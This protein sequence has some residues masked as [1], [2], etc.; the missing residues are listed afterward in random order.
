LLSDGVFQGVYA[1]DFSLA[2]ISFEMDRFLEEQ[3]SDQLGWAFVVERSGE[4]LGRLVGATGG[5]LL[6][7]RDTTQRVQAVD[8]QN[9]SARDLAQ[10][11]AI[12]GWPEDMFLNFEKPGAVNMCILKRM[13]PG[14]DCPQQYTPWESEALDLSRFAGPARCAADERNCIRSNVEFCRSAPTIGVVVSSPEWTAPDSFV[15]TGAWFN[16]SE[17]LRTGRQCQTMCQEVSGCSHFTYESG[18]TPYEAISIIFKGDDE[19]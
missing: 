14:V 15:R 1:I 12:E 18:F 2:S 8:S 16:V 10:R 9:P 13:D 4:N 3:D 7:D 19:L 6:Y 17:T 11:L 5:Q